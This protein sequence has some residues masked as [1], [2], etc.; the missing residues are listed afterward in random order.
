MVNWAVCVSFKFIWSIGQTFGPPLGRCHIQHVTYIYIESLSTYFENCL[1][2]WYVSQESLDGWAAIAGPSSSERKIMDGDNFQ[3]YLA[4][5][6]NVSICNVIYVHWPFH[7]GLL[8]LIH[9]FSQVL[10]SISIS[11][12]LLSPY[13]LW[14]ML[15]FCFSMRLLHILNFSYATK[16]LLW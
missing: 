3:N 16:L 12:L 13:M 9:L 15:D 7:L 4:G 8:L 11:N 10:I 5:R 2:P 14:K 6:I 1:L